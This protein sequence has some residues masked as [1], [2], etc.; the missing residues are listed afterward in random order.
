M[1][2][3]NKLWMF[4][5][6]VIICWS[7]LMLIGSTWGCGL[8]YLTQIKLPIDFFF[9]LKGK[10]RLLDRQTSSIY[11]PKTRPAVKVIS[12]TNLPKFSSRPN[13]KRTKWILTILAKAEWNRS[14]MNSTENDLWQAFCILVALSNLSDLITFNSLLIKEL[15]PKIASNRH[16]L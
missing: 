16:K 10:W 7:K 1:H 8:N 2:F 6:G 9:K 11:T 4:V 15:E 5:C 12:K 13:Y 3:A 14:R